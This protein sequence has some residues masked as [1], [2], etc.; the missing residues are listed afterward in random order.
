MTGP[1]RLG[2]CFRRGDDLSGHCHPRAS[3]R[4]PGVKRRGRGSSGARR[5]AGGA[6]DG[7]PSPGPLLSRGRRSLRTLSCSRKSKIPGAKRRGRGSSGARRRAG[8]AVDGAPSPGP[9]LS[10]GRRSL[11]TLSSPRKSKIP[12]AKQRGRGSRG[13]SPSSDR[14]CSRAPIAW[15]PAPLRS[16]SGVS[17][18]RKGDGELCPASALCVSQVVDRAGSTERPEGARAPTAAEGRIAN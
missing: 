10:R 11:R 14:R 6:V 18:F 5:R 13:D 8:G 1:L 12:G 16:A 2:P 17:D 4:S 9:P 7:A 3:R 15:A